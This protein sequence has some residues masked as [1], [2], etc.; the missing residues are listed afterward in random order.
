MTTSESQTDVIRTVLFDFGGVLAEEGF[1]DGLKVIARR[2]GLEPE[3]FYKLGAEAV[4]DSGYVTG[5][6]DEGDFWNL[7]CRKSDLERYE[8]WFTR[9]I[10]QRFVL[11]PRMLALASELRRQGLV[12]AVLS[13]QTDWLD[14][15][16][17]RDHFFRQFDRVFNSYHIG[18]GKRDPGL[19]DEVVQTLKAKPNEILFVDDNIGHV[20]RA[21][22]RGLKALLFLDEES[23][24]SD[25][26]AS[27]PLSG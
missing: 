17:A 8:E 10:L 14:K 18:R 2:R 4:Y 9:E 5:E 1:R 16:D 7:M 12:V 11:R 23:F 19:F 22:S 20:E 24:F 6:G 27:L 25:L 21:R 3:A 13:D 26:P 15:L